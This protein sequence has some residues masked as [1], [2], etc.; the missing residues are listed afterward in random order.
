MKLSEIKAERAVEVI[1]E[2]IAPI[3]NIAQDQDSLKLFHAEKRDGET[4]RDAAVRDIKVK[5]PALL[6]THKADVLA[7]LCAVNDTDPSELSMVDIIKGIIDLIND[8]DFLSLFLSAVSQAEPTLPTESS[9]D[10]GVSE[11]E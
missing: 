3:V 9:A 2:L 11:P 1:A 8:K 5:I 10:A 6:K 4:D 7:I